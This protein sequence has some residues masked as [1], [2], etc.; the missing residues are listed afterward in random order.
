MAI[1]ADVEVRGVT[2]EGAYIRVEP[3][4]LGKF[5]L[6]FRVSMLVNEAAVP[7]AV[8]DRSCAYDLKGPNPWVQ[9]YHYLKGLP[10]FAGAV[11][12]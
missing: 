11:D 7:F 10:A 5:V 8:E 1:R 9:A 12:C 3:H 2:I 4:T 6:G